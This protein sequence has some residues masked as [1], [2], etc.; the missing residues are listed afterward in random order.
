MQVNILILVFAATLA[1]NPLAA[2]FHSLHPRHDD[3]IIQGQQSRKARSR[4]LVTN[5]GTQIGVPFSQEK[6]NNA[7]DLLKTQGGLPT[8]IEC[9]DDGDSATCLK[10]NN[11]PGQSGLINEVLDEVWEGIGFNCPDY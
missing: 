2:A 8:A 3:T 4:G 9:Y 10:F 1:N 7:S 11:L 6:C 5:C